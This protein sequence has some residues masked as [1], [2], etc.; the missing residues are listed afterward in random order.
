MLTDL[1][2]QSIRG[3][4][5]RI[6]AARDVAEPASTLHYVRSELKPEHLAWLS[7]M[8]AAALINNS[9][10][11]CHG[12]PR[13]DTEYLFWDVRS[14]GAVPR[15]RD[16]IKEMT[17]GI[18]SA[19]RLCGHDHVPNSAVIPG[20]TLI[21]NP[22]SVGLPA[23]LDEAPFFHVM[24]NH[25]PHARY[26]LVSEEQGRWRIEHRQV[27]YDWE[28]AAALASEHGRTDWAYWLRTGKARAD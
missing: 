4:E 24:Q 15:S 8:P 17:E 20:G 7:R 27:L 2:I 18:R 5:D 25:T 1:D 3:N 6:V 22:G 10:F 13:A 12:S 19:V 11:A 9:F 14:S 28:A 16:E 23:Y 21:V 26:A